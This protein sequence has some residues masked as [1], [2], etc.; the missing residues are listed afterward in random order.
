ME[1]EAYGDGSVRGL[2][3]LPGFKPGAP[4]KRGGWV[5]FPH[6]SATNLYKMKKIFPLFL[7]IL[8]LLNP[9]N[10]FA[11]ISIK[12]EKIYGKQL[13]NAL[14][15]N[16]KFFKDPESLAYLNTLGN[17]LIKKG[18]SLSPFKFHFYLIKDDSF[19]AFS[20]PGGYILVNTGVFASIKDE[21]Q[22]AGILAHEIAHNLARHVAKQI[23]LMNKYQLAAITAIITALLIGGP[24]AGQ[25]AGIT[26]MALAQ[27]KLLSYTRAEEEEADKIGMKILVKTGYN[28]WG[29]VKIMQ[30]LSQKSGLAVELNYRYLLTHPLPP[31][32]VI[33]LST[34]AKKITSNK[35]DI[36][37]VIKDPVYFKRLKIKITTAGKDPLQ[38]I[39]YCRELLLIKKDPWKR[40]IFAFALENAKFYKRAINQL[41][42]AIKKLPQ[43]KY[44]KLDLAEIYIKW[45][46]FS[47]ALNILKNL[48]FTNDTYV[49]KFCNLKKEYLLA[50]AYYGTGNYSQAYLIFKKL[51]NS[52]RELFKKNFF[53][54][55]MYG[56]SALQTGEQGIGHYLFGRYYQLLGN[57]I[58]AIF[59]YKKALL[60][61][62]K[63]DK[64][65]KMTKR[66]LKI[67]KA[68]TSREE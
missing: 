66:Y 39:S 47:E 53:F 23:E 19:N 57:Y 52:Y 45:G 51:F 46:K 42:Q 36:S 5:Q 33:Y 37:L 48:N 41:K 2:V 9:F 56:V 59:H 4:L 25:V 38:L 49:S 24:E 62:N 32:R 40:L 6:A 11:L 20:L 3:S 21:N 54:L 61:L 15:K 18:V 30:E 35:K 43:K 29:M 12:T 8:L 63:K 27:T 68:K 55:Y 50:R 28:P 64:M 16:L 1:I 65:Y 7:I 17:L 60:F 22:L 34:I 13:F 26:S 14:S 58:A 10:S 31:E 67:L 44:F